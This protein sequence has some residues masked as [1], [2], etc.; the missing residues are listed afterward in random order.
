[1]ICA[2]LVYI[3]FY[4]SPR[5]NMDYYSIVRTVNN[6]GVTIPS[7]RRYVYYFSHLRKRNLNYM[8][9]RCELI[10]VY[11]EKPPRLN[12]WSLSSLP[13]FANFVLSTIVEGSFPWR[14]VG[15]G[16]RRSFLG[17]S[18]CEDSGREMEKDIFAQ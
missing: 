12:G 6:K 4:L 1:M 2:Y 7:Q 8:P 14:G 10:G 3:N 15:E 18:E 11:F 17:S 13:F 9:L 16:G 5:Q